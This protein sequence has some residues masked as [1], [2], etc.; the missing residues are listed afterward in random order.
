[1]PGARI[2]DGAE[3]ELGSVVGGEV[4]AGE[5]WGGSPAVRVGSAGERWPAT[6][7]PPVRHARRWKLMFAAGLAFDNLLALLAAV[8]GLVLVLE[9]LPSRWT[10]TSG[11]VTLLE[12]APVLALSFLVA[13]ALL[14][15]VMVRLVAPLIRP[16]WQAGAGAT[17]WALW[18]TESLMAAS[19]GAL[20]SVYSSVYTRSWLRALG[21]SVGRRTEVSTAT[22]LTHLS[23]FAATSFA[24]DDV[25]FGHGRSRDG[26]LYVAPIAVG[27]RSFLGNGALLE[28]GTTIGSDSLV[29]LM[30]TP[31]RDG[32]DGTSWLGC[33]PIELPR[34]SHPADP[35]HTVAPGRA[36]IIA[37]A[38]I[39]LV[40]ILL[41]ATIS[42]ALGSIIFLAIDRAGVAGG[43][44]AMLATAPLAELAGGIAAAA[45]TIAFK[46]LLM[47]RYRPGDHPLW[48]FFVWRD[49]IINS[50]QE[51]LAGP[52]L[53][54]LCLATPV[55]NLYLR[56]MG[57]RV[58]RD[59][60]CE[61]LN[62]TE[63]DLARLDDGAVANRY[64]VIETHLFHDRVMQVGP[65]RL[66]AGATLGPLS[67][68]LPETEIGDGCSVGARSI[69]MRGER[70]PPGT[71]WH[72]AP[73]VSAGG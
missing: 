7:P 60:W 48:S 73:V 26:W 2:G 41:P 21:V 39:E 23:S 33:P 57:A 69:V 29:G 40:R 13:Y 43:V 8:P 25:V 4:P 45:I 37:R 20:F 38:T 44:W 36:R 67:A 10:L 17:G 71:R 59:V 65:A 9:L 16:G 46:W 35:R 22:G 49:E 19:R 3:I 6:G 18:F 34:R 1:M 66:G 54:T 30:T 14:I 55:M 64:S 63:F 56:A 72:G 11:T 52:W 42:V 51:Q 62:V 47:G 5:R 24:A 58:G 15:V 53:L 27:E 68:T 70:L 32:A 12:L 31:P 50:L 28:G 61:T